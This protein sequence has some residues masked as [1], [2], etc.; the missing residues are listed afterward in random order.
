MIF[1]RIFA[2][3]VDKGR[4]FGLDILRAAAIL[5]VVIALSIIVKSPVFVNDAS[6]LIATAVATFDTLPT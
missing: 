3:N 2:L 5:F 1:R 6:P 4:V